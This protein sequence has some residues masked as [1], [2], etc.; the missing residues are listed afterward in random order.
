[1]KKRLTPTL[2]GIL[3]ARELPKQKTPRFAAGGFLLSLQTRI[4][5][6]KHLRGSVWALNH[7]L[8][9]PAPIIQKMVSMWCQ[10]HGVC[11]VNAED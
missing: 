10:I 1:M 2:P 3:S 5:P 7:A 6:C 9:L 8:G 11:A 4:T